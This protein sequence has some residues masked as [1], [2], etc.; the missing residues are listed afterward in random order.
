M[1]PLKTP[2]GTTSD[3]DY[4][5]AETLNAQFQSNWSHEDLS[6]LRSFSEEN[7]SWYW[8]HCRNN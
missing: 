1:P 2:A 6:K 8:E 3:S 4:E 7:H 5:K